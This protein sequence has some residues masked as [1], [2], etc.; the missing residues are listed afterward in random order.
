ME[1]RQENITFEPGD[2]EAW[3]CIC[4]NM[5]AEFGFY[6]CDRKGNMV[7]PTEKDWTAGLYV[8]NHCGRIIDPDTLAVVGRNGEIAARYEKEIASE[9]DRAQTDFEKW[10][11]KSQPHST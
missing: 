1:E 6:A 2:P 4:R 9:R 5:P 7:E 8:C 11:D 3:I 10:I